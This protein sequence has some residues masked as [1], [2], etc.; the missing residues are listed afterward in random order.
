MKSVSIAHVVAASQR[1]WASLPAELAGSIVLEAADKLAAPVGL[2]ARDVLLFSDGSIHINGGVSCSDESAVH[3]LR[4]LLDILLAAACSTTPALLRS[5][6]REVD[7]SIELF[8]RELEVALIPTNRGAAKRALARL[9]REVEREVAA[10]PQVLQAANPEAV[11]GRSGAI[12][13]VRDAPGPIEIDVIFDA[14]AEP[15]SEMFASG[16][17]GH[18]N[19]IGLESLDGSKIDIPDLEMPAPRRVPREIQ[20]T[21]SPCVDRTLEVPPVLDASP[22]PSAN[23]RTALPT[24]LTH[25]VVAEH[26]NL[27]QQVSPNIEALDDQDVLEIPDCEIELVESLGAT[28]EP[29]P[30]LVPA[31]LRR[32]CCI[33][34]HIDSNEKPATVSPNHQNPIEDTTDQTTADSVPVG[35]MAP[36]A[37]ASSAGEPSPVARVDNVTSRPV[38]G[39][40]QFVAGARFVKKPTSMSERL[41]NF[42]S[43]E[44][45]QPDELIDRLRSLAE[46]SR[47]STLSFSQARSARECKAEHHRPKRANES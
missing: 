20:A 36:D 32:E 1:R 30:L 12:P 31:R 8:V 35:G 25:F 43:R 40:H 22:E 3:S 21:E 4:Q 45:T 18:D 15:K 6:R 16:S 24:G 5:A 39:P 29:F 9:Y 44:G 37:A 2:C 46:S 27:L 7:G 10:Q 14:A 34:G 41:A 17:L 23:S 38:T 33:R 19:S 11:G 42:S 13:S 47:D 26:P 28:T